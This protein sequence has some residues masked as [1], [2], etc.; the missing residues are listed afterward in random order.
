MAVRSSDEVNVA[1]RR[2]RR[3]S[4]VGIKRQAK[5]FQRNPIPRQTKEPMPIMS[6]RL[7][8]TLVILALL[9]AGCRPQTSP[10]KKLPFDDIPLGM[11]FEEA[12]KLIGREGK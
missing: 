6:Q 4:L 5:S 11:S 12:K 8:W 2:S 7:L 3:V 9:I 1:R 10:P